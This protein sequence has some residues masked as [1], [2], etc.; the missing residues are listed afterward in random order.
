MCVFRCVLPSSVQDLSYNQ[1]TEIPRDLENSRNMLVLN[2]SHNRYGLSVLYPSSWKWDIMITHDFFFI[3]IYW[4]VIMLFWMIWGAYSKDAFLCPLIARLSAT[5][6]ME[7]NAGTLRHVFKSWTIFNFTHHLR[8]AMH[9]AQD[10]ENPMKNQWSIHLYQWF[11]T[12]LPPRPSHCP[13][14]YLKA[15]WHFWVFVISW[16][17]INDNYFWKYFTHNFC[18]I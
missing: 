1:L 12:F 5:E 6:G 4:S 18:L 16:I 10:A 13:Q 2:L 11:S 17:R 3:Y 8:N 9:M 14:L 15:P 7:K